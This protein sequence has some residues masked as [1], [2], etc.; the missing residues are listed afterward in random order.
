M[1]AAVSD[2]YREGVRLAAAG[3]HFDA[4]GRLERAL[5]VEPNNPHVLFALANTARALGLAKQTEVFLRMVLANDPG[6]LEAVVVLGNFLSSQGRH[7]EAV[8]LLQQALEANADAPELMLT[9]GVVYRA[10]GDENIAETHLRRALDLK[11]GYALALGN[12][13]SIL[14]DRGEYDEALR[15]CD[16]VLAEL[17]GNAQARLNRAVLHLLTGNFDAGWRD[18]AA[19]L[20]IPGK[21][22]VADHGLPAWN[23]VFRAGMRLLVTGEQGVGDQIMFAGIL[24][25]LAAKADAA[26]AR[27]VVECEPR[28]VDLFARSFP[29]LRVCPWSIERRDGTVRAHYDWLKDAGGADAAVAMGGLPIFLRTRIEDFSAVPSYLRIDA[30]EKAHWR[31]AFADL[32]RPLTAICWRSGKTGGERAMQY[33]PLECWAGAIRD[34]PGTVICAQYDAEADEIAALAETGNRPI[35]V[36]AGIDQ[37]CEL[38]RTA[39]M[40]A[41][42]DVLV[43]APTAVSWLAAAAGVPTY[44]MVRDPA[45]TGFGRPYEPFAPSAVFVVPPAAGDWAASFATLRDR[46][47]R[48][49][50]AI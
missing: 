15:L 8:T 7:D 47:D 4:I 6:R 38:D 3:R 13:A 32:P 19:R 1:N 28:L 22:P 16:R 44:K 26:D 17:P 36:P 11:P 41:A 14:S 24:P 45:W 33:A 37:R 5:A 21:T 31:K 39:A 25:D 29:S 50:P 46:L 40:L 20:N 35:V 43:S 2:L 12:L 34:L 42:V 10:A 48:R 30:A 18:Y 9:L 49:N 27:V 23:G